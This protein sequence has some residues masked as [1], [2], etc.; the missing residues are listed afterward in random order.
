MKQMILLSITAAVLLTGC[1]PDMSKMK[2]DET[3]LVSTGTPFIKK[4]VSE[5]EY[6]G[7][8][9]SPKVIEIRSRVPGFIEHQYFK[10]GSFVKAGDKLYKIDN[11]QTEADLTYAKAQLDQAV[12]EEQNMISISKKIDAAVKIG[13]VSKQDQETAAVNMNKATAMVK[14]NRAS[15]EKLKLNMD[16][17]TIVA[18]SSGYIEKSKSN[19]GAYV[20]VPSEPLTNIFTTK[21]LYLS[22]MVPMSEKEWS[23]NTISIND[24]KS[25]GILDYCDPMADTSSGLVKCRFKFE[26]A[27]PVAINSLGK[28]K[29]KVEKEGMFIPQ[30]ALVQNADGKSVYLYAGKK[31]LSRK[32]TTGVWSEG[33]IQVLSG[34][35]MKTEI[36]ING[37]ANVRNEGPIKKAAK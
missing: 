13:A 7:I 2:R 31:A 26:S 20:S 27:T 32:I 29:F 17:S 4:Y 34:V 6:T 28:I 30:T 19:E 25:K 1:K 23:N 10:D 35:S 14:M 9:E 16:Y 36:I 33:N 8:V 22:V 12:A 11:K 24:K 18:P 21:F 5:T 15:I 37:V 3:A